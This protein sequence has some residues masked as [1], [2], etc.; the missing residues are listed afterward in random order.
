MRKST[1]LKFWISLF[2]AS[3]LLLYLFAFSSLTT[4][5]PQRLLNGNDED[6]VFEAND[7]LFGKESLQMQ[8]RSKENKPSS[9]S[10]SERDPN[11]WK[12]LGQSLS[13]LYPKI[14]L[15]VTSFEGSDGKKVLPVL[16]E[17]THLCELGFDVDIHVL[18]VDDFPPDVVASH[19][20]T[21]FCNRNFLQLR[22]HNYRKY[23]PSHST[24][25]R[26][27]TKQNL[28]DYSLFVHTQEGVHVTNHHVLIFLSEHLHLHSGT[29]KS[30]LSNMKSYMPGFIRYSKDAATGTA[31]VQQIS[32]TDLHVASFGNFSYVISSA[33]HDQGFWMAVPEQLKLL[34]A[35]CEFLEPSESAVAD[36]PFGLFVGGRQIYSPKYCNR[37]KFF[38]ANIID[39][40]M[41]LDERD[42]IQLEKSAENGYVEQDQF[43]CSGI[44]CDKNPNN[45]ASEHCILPK[46]EAIGVCNAD[47]ECVCYG[48]AQ[49]HSGWLAAFPD[50]FQ[51][52]THLNENKHWQSFQKAETFRLRVEDIQ[53]SIE[54]KV[55]AKNSFKA[56]VPTQ[57]MTGGPPLYGLA[58]WPHAVANPFVCS[59]ERCMGLLSL[60]LPVPEDEQCSWTTSRD[61]SR[62]QRCA[63]IMAPIQLTE[64]VK[65]RPVMDPG[66]LKSV[67][68]KIQETSEWAYKA[69]MPEETFKEIE[70]HTLETSPRVLFVFSSTDRGERA[71]D[72]QG[73][74][75]IFML[76]VVQELTKMC[77][78]GFDIH[79]HFITNYVIS[80]ELK[81]I[82]QYTYCTRM[83]STYPISFEEY[84]FP[85][86]GDLSYKHRRIF[87][88]KIDAYD[89]F[90]HAEDD[91]FI[92]RN[93][94]YA[95]S[96]VSSELKTL[97]EKK[98]HRAYLT[99][100]FRIEK[101]H[102]MKDELGEHPYPWEKGDEYYSWE[103][104]AD[105]F[106]PLP[107]GTTDTPL[108]ALYG[109]R[110]QA[111]SISTREELL[112]LNE[113][114][115]F[116]WPLP[117]VNQWVEWWSGGIEMFRDHVKVLPSDELFWSFAV[118][119]LAN[120]KHGK[121]GN[122]PPT[123]LSLIGT[124]IG[125]KNAETHGHNRMHTG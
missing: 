103:N 109:D 85:I 102:S 51:L 79:L 59:W 11:S 24:A 25:H 73:D 28:E 61:P 84:K 72:F 86:E 33:D 70:Q 92:T 87:T 121:R 107:V 105:E 31:F 8:S 113:S 60:R 9:L 6:R 46:E 18:S 3:V 115:R 7:F 110:N 88:E 1:K 98:S 69:A 66:L 114:I 5:L 20:N 68:R 116:L 99:G 50:V 83:G 81:L 47:P 95:T 23:G 40:W 19:H 117:M 124:R 101:G 27:L 2:L 82:Q 53:K 97:R 90:I 37:K 22:H 104:E 112:M 65:K 55:E 13:T 14:L 123:P 4:H 48:S 38:P 32:L 16:K 64:P 17:F 45:K 100:A 56:R 26:A 77:E 108:V 15:I 42:L 122:I 49:H 119:H 80:Q 120:N 78:V 52:G 93:I 54:V 91:M 44:I 36:S 29:T 71:D 62:K 34:Q 58:E 63:E 94:I 35:D 76:M 57:S 75:V 30:K 118:H 41:V 21:A 67:R 125:L 89:M 12:G 96:K 106:K 111:L 39:E 10:D 74:K 43:S